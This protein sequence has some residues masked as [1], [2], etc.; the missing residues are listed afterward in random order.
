MA[1]V[2]AEAT[3]VPWLIWKTPAGRAR[4]FSSRPK[5]GSPSF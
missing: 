5:S 2:I 3:R 1:D 4:T